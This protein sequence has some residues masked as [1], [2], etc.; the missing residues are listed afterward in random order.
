MGSR[1]ASSGLKKQSSQTSGRSG[2]NLKEEF[3]RSGAT[4]SEKDFIGFINK[5]IGVDLNLYRDSYTRKYDKKN[6]DSF[7]IYP[8]GMSKDSLMKLRS[9]ANSNIGK[10]HFILQDDG[11]LGILV[12]YGKELEKYK[13]KMKKL[14]S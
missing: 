9:F 2:G 7:H 13:K 3:G 1:G 8:S 10:K 12:T 11:G 4:K 5:Q 14:W 6:S